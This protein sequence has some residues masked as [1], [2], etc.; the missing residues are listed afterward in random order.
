MEQVLKKRFE[1]LR[2]GEPWVRENLTL[3]P[4]M[5][6]QG[7]GPRYYEMLDEALQGGRLE[8]RE[9]SE[10]GS[11]NQI[12]VIN[13]GDKPVL[14][15]DGEELVGAKQNRLVNAT[16][17]IAAQV[18]LVI[19]VSCVERGRWHHTSA[20]FSSSEVFGYSRLR[21]QKAAGVTAN[22]RMYE[23]F[24]S[25]QRAVWE[26]IDRKQAAMGSHSA[27]AAMHDMFVDYEA[28]ME[29]YT[30]GVETLPGQVGVMVFVNGSF[31][32]LDIL[33]HSDA[34][35]RLWSKLIKSY[36]MEALEVRGDKPSYKAP[37]PEQ[38]WQQ[39]CQAR[40]VF[41]KSPGLGTDFRIQT[42]SYIGAGLIDSEQVL[43]FSAFPVMNDTNAVEGRIARPSRRRRNQGYYLD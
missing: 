5:A 4:I 14:I 29:K 34:L 35:S 12:K 41:Y 25:D 32:C 43:H 22:L 38:V 26:E 7:S 3:I 28:E 36:A 33:G 16:L 9:T 42:D 13:K 37:Q 18:E 11:V 30:A 19:P 40:P 8:A 27:T 21:G 17:L 2:L 24:A 6:E 23:V 1:T 20:A 10:G 15:L 31:N 39:L